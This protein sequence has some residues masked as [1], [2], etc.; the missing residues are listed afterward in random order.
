MTQKWFIFSLHLRRVHN[1]LHTYRSAQKKLP[2]FGYNAVDINVLLVR[3][4][5]NFLWFLK[6]VLLIKTSLYFIFI[7]WCFWSHK[8]VH[9]IYRRTFYVSCW[10]AEQPSAIL[11]CF[12]DV[13]YFIQMWVMRHI[14]RKKIHF[15][16]KNILS[17]LMLC[18]DWC[19]LLK[20]NT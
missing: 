18:P 7:S 9:V 16:F 15:V 12:L 13:I 10:A 11:L 20:K 17:F 14:Q 5:N 8:W 19:T 3:S 6:N 1:W 4:E 2:E